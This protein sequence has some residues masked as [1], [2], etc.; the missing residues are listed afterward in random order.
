MNDIRQKIFP[1]HDPFKDLVLDRPADIQGWY[2]NPELLCKLYDQGG[3]T[4]GI[5]VGT[6]K[7]N[8]AIAVAKHLRELGHP[9]HLVC[10]DTWTASFEHWI[11]DH[12]RALWTFKH[13][14]PDLYETFLCNVVH[15]GL[16]DFI[17]PFPV[18]S[19]TAAKYFNHLGVKAGYI[20]V[21]GSHQE[22]DVWAD[23]NAWWPV[24]AEGGVM[25]GDDYIS[26]VG[27]TNS[28]NRFAQEKGL[29]L[30]VN[31]V[32]WWMTKPGW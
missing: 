23:L 13:G 3:N 16:Q 15:E 12:S 22:D 2:L 29:R 4:L 24:L 26:W 5:E 7:G 9:H 28:V 10:V 11:E 20:F 21:D 27:V 32:N 31:H 25:A 14:R 30:E 1:I 17:T 8:S 6:W 18:P 19:T